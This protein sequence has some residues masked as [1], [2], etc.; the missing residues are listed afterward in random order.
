MTSVV[1]AVAVDCV[2]MTAG[3]ARGMPLETSWAG[4]AERRIRNVTWRINRILLLKVMVVVDCWTLWR[5]VG[6][7]RI[8]PF[9]CP[10]C[11]SYS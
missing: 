8:G 1:V 2:G 10:S 9:Q 5:G 11:S 4:W 6:E 7:T 3:L